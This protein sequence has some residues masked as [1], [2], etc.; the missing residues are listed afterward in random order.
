VDGHK[1]PGKTAF[2]LGGDCVDSSFESDK[3][4]IQA[5]GHLSILE[6]GCT[7]RANGFGAAP[8]GTPTGAGC[9]SVAGAVNSQSWAE[10]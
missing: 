10:S 4:M 7:T 9:E 5:L 8:T 2:C 1:Y 3:D 6:G